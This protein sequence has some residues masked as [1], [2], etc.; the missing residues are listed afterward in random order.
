MSVTATNLTEGL[1]GDVTSASFYGLISGDG[2]TKVIPVT[3]NVPV[4]IDLATNLDSM[5]NSYFSDSGNGKISYTGSPDIEVRILAI[6]TFELVSSGVNE[7]TL[8]LMVDSGSGP[9]SG[10]NFGDLEINAD[11]QSFM[12]VKPLTISQNDELSI[13]FTNKATSIDIRARA[14]QIEITPL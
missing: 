5:S 14:F 12:A 8:D 13:E 9:V 10:Y 6:P 7:M 3:I 11:L 2:S 4:Q 1:G